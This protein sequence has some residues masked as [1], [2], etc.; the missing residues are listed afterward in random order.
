MQ[1]KN[2]DITLRYIK[3]DDIKNYINW[4]TV[5]TEW[6]KW[7]SPWVQDENNDNFLNWQKELIK[8]EPTAK[9]L[10][11]EMP[12][13]EHIGWVSS[14]Y[15]NGDKEKIAMGIDIPPMSARRKGYGKAALT[16]FMESLF[17]TKEILYIQTWSGNLAMI[18]LSEKLGFNEVKWL[19][20][21]REGNG[22]KYDILTYSITKDE[23]L[24]HKRGT[25]G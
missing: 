7:D 10:E 18:A 8:K 20:D 13:G 15:I 11:I 2:D 5:E 24:S 22:E 23:F 17:E 6:L 4:T 16:L 19:K 1:L 14:Y 9:K 12:N 25:K 21:L 3:E